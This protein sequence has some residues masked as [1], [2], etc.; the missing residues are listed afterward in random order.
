M[1][2]IIKVKKKKKKKTQ[3]ALL[4]I[5]SWERGEKRWIYAFLKIISTKWNSNSPVQDV[6]L[7]HCEHCL[8]R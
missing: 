4:F 1:G 5:H 7:G 6:N 2:Y 8:Q 3:S